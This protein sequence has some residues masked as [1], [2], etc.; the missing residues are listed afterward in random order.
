MKICRRCIVKGR[1]QGVFYRSTTRQQAIKLGISGYVKNRHDGSVE[2]LACGE[3]DATDALCKWLWQGPPLAEV[4]SVE[5]TSLQ[6]EPGND[7]LIF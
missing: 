7:F 2:V 6:Q 1:V 5:C 4:S 3:Q